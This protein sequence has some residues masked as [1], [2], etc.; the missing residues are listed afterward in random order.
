MKSITAKIVAFATACLITV[1]VFAATPE[2]QD[3]GESAELLASNDIRTKLKSK[4]FRQSF[5]TSAAC[6]DFEKQSNALMTRYEI[7]FSNP[8]E[9]RKF[10]SDVAV[11]FDECSRSATFEKSKLRYAYETNFNGWKLLQAVWERGVSACA[12]GDRLLRSAGG[13]GF[14]NCKWG[15]MPLQDYEGESVVRALKSSISGYDQLIERISE[16][17]KYRHFFG[18]IQQAVGARLIKF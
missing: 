4:G 16:R 13:G 5:K 12:A 7:G 18:P 8:D 1:S 9:G 2:A 6:R 10:L 15:E 14:N 11:S 17:N 3:L